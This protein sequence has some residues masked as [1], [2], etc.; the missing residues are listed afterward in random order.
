MSLLAMI[1]LSS[2]QSFVQTF[3]HNAI[4]F[5]DT[6]NNTWYNQAHWLIGIPYLSIIASNELFALPE[7]WYR[8]CVIRM[9]IIWR[10]LL[11]GFRPAASHVGDQ[12][13]TTAPTRHRW[14]TGSLN[15]PQFI[16]QWFIRIP[17]LTEFPF[18][19]ERTLCTSVVSCYH[20]SL[21]SL[22]N[23]K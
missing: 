18:H 2:V 6:S 21:E 14:E 1:A 3:I 19:L 12:D 17:E 22:E 20:H 7:G 8:V 16:L 11:K 15:W 9:L 13:A 23:L 10:L 4:L 5:I